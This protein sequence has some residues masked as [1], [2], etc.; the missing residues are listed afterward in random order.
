MKL[1]II[2]NS[3]DSLHVFF[4]AAITLIAVTPFLALTIILGT[5]ARSTCTKVPH[6]HF[7][8]SIFLW[9]DSTGLIIDSNGNESSQMD[10]I[11][12]DGSK[13][14]IFYENRSLCV[15]PVVCVYAVI[16]VKSI[17][18]LI[19]KVT[20]ARDAKNYHPCRSGKTNRFRSWR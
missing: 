8:D 4:P 14:P 5:Q 10:I 6:R 7:P 16:K 15:H 11:V 18:I 9:I 17:L 3:K 12:S 2:S 20:I 19:A 1:S 13:T